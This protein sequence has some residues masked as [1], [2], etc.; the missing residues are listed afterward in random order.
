MMFTVSWVFFP[1][2]VFVTLP[3][4]LLAKIAI[5]ARPGREGSS[6]GIVLAAGSIGAIF[7][8]I[9]AGFVTLPLTRS[10]TTFEK[11]PPFFAC[12]LSKVVHQETLG[13]NT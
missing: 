13:S 10:T 1:A 3:S 4:P 8:A 12:R 2:S 6:L 9:L 11:K 5:E 7:G